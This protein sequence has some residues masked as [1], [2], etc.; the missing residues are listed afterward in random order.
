MEIGH[1]VAWMEQIAEPE[2]HPSPAVI[3]AGSHR[4]V[5]HDALT[6]SQNKAKDLH[7]GCIWIQT[8][9]EIEMG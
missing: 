2:R 8:T 6:Q 9:I 7:F 1:R 3:H 4:R 5:N